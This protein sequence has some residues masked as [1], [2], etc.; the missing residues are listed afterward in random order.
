MRLAII[1]LATIL[2]FVRGHSDPRDG[3]AGLPKLVGGR[4][5]MASLKGCNIADAVPSVVQER[6]PIQLGA[7]LEARFT[8]NCGSGVGNCDAGYCCSSAG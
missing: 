3:N 8:Q 6:V 7:Q 4:K 1:L 2:A 5:F